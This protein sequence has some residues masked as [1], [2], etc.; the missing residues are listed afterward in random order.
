MKSTEIYCIFIYFFFQIKTRL[1]AHV[2]DFP[3]QA[4]DSGMGDLVNQAVVILIIRDSFGNR[5]SG[6][7]R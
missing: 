3:N 6:F 2:E 7:H 5:V 4:A 1:H